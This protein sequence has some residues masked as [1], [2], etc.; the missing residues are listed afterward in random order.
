MQLMRKHKKYFRPWTKSGT[1]CNKTC[2]YDSIEHFYRNETGNNQKA[3]HNMEYRGSGKNKG[4]KKTDIIRYIFE[5]KNASKTELTK[6]LGLS[7]PT[8]LQNTKE[9]LEQ[10]MLIE[11]GEYESTGGR[12]AKTLAINGQIR[13]VVGLDITTDH[14]S[15]VLMDLAGTIVSRVRKN[16]K[17]SNSIE[18]FRSLTLYVDQLLDGI[19]ID[20][21]IVLGIGIALPGN[22]NDGEKIL[23][24]SHALNLEGV[25]LKMIEGF[26]PY[27]IHFE[28]D[29]NAAMVAEREH[30]GENAI[31]LFL[32]NTVGSAIKIEGTVYRGEN[33]KAGEVGHV[34]LVPNG[35][36]CYCGKDGCVDSYCS[37]HALEEES[38]IAL[39]EFMKLVEK[40]DP[41]VMKVWENYLDYLAITISNLRMIHD[42][43]L[44][45]G[46]DMGEYLEGYMLELGK[47]VM[48]YNKY[49][50]DTS[51][52]KIS[53]YKKDSAAIGAA[54]HFIYQYFDNIY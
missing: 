3:E 17:F 28:N 16:W 9:L 48:K 24:K 26:I 32:S 39:D 12:R 52:L 1:I 42:T 8:V 46:G 22:I 34:T 47:R 7:M 44:I 25:N 4:N 29:A 14:V 40:R 31:Y 23:I 19:G 27:P 21:E 45:L 43:E 33:R 20:H 51:Y 41:A 49:D 35:R 53:K 36:P 2:V 54:M 18:Y 6:V 50:A 5:N 11:I 15:Y 30:V 13:Y 38:G 10:G 37:V